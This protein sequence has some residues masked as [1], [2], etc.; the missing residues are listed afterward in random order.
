MKCECGNDKFYAHQVCHMDVV[1]N[2]HNDWES[3]HPDSESCCY[4]SDNPFGPYVCTECDKEYPDL[5]KRRE[6]LMKAQEDI[7]EDF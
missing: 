4:E 2:E 3:N 6:N 7:A 5:S 1:V